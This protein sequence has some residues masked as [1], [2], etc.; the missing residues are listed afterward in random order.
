MG[1][2]REKSNNKII[3][4]IMSD[5]GCTNI[6]FAK[7]IKMGKDEILWQKGRGNG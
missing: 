5:F 6:V 4:K 2:K 3:K 7:Y 1:S